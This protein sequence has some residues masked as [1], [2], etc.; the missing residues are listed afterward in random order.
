MLKRIATLAAG[1]L[2]LATFAMV[3]AASARSSHHRRHPTSHHR[4]IYSHPASAI[5]DQVLAW[6][7]ELQTVLVAP[8]AQ[9]ASIHPTRTLAITQIAVYDAV[10]GIVR[11]GQPLLVDARG[12]RDASPNAAA[13]SAARTALGRQ[14]QPIK[15][16]RQGAL[17]RGAGRKG[18]CPGDRTQKACDRRLPPRRGLA[19][20]AA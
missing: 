11:D 12:P 15:T 14:R 5:P 4:A 3:A 13:A 19:P 10:N 2:L 18:F 6:N 8:G 9:P 20:A 1:A 7:Q 16:A 17:T